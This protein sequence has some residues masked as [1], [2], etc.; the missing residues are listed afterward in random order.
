MKLDFYLADFKKLVD[1]FGGMQDH[2][3]EIVFVRELPGNMK[4]HL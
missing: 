3:T 1:L 2:A 4:K